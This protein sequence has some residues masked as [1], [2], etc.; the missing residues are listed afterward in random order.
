[1]SPEPIAKLRGKNYFI[2]LKEWRD[3][4]DNWMYKV[5]FVDSKEIDLN[6]VYGN[7]IKSDLDPDAFMSVEDYDLFWGRDERSHNKAN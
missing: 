4:N 1:M 7:D 2:N 6:N 3:Q 5:G